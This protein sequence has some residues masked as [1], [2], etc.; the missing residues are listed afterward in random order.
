MLRNGPCAGALGGLQITDILEWE[1]RLTIE[2][3]A[4]NKCALMIAAMVLAAGLT[5]TGA[6]AQAHPDIAPVVAEAQ[7]L[8]IKND[9][10]GL[11]RTRMKQLAVLRRESRPVEIR[12]RVCFS[13]CTMFLGLPETCVSPN[14]TF[15]FHGPS[16]YGRRLDHATFERASEIIASHYPPV[17]KNWYMKKGRH[18]IWA[19]Y[20]VSGSNLIALGVPS[21]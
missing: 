20:R 6:S 7:P 2:G 5:P 21:C 9:R 19:L 13:T 11:L 14:T 17:L 12:G 3:A 1:M 15:G 18:R 4:L 8:V 10:G 16:S